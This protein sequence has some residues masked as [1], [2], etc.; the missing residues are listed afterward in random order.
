MPRRRARFLR[1]CSLVP[2]VIVS[3]AMSA[4]THGVRVPWDQTT[5]AS[6]R[7]CATRAAWDL[8]FAV[9]RFEVVGWDTY[10]TEHGSVIA[11]GN[12]K[13]FIDLSLW[14]WFIGSLALPVITRTVRIGPR[15]ESVGF[16]V[17]PTVR[18]GFTV[19]TEM[20]RGSR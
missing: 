3:L 14:P 2:L 5:T 8:R 9:E 20:Q 11:F 12:W 10:R 1:V 13:P 19:Q 15:E 6:I 18:N 7:V 17:E 16:T 4:A